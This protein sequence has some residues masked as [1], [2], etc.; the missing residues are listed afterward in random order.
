MGET[1]RFVF[2][3]EL[4]VVSPSFPTLFGLMPYH[5]T[6]KIQI[7]FIEEKKL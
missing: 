2:G 5:L 1:K 3:E 7:R 4:Q 6:L